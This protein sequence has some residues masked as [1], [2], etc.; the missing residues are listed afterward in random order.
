MIESI[1]RQFIVYEKFDAIH[2][3]IDYK[4]SV[5]R[6][7]LKEIK[8]KLFLFDKYNKIILFLIKFILIL[9]NKLFIMKHVFN[10]KKTIL[11]KIIMQE[12]ILSHTYEDDG[13]SNN[14][15]KTINSSIINLI[16][17][18]RQNSSFQ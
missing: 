18:S 14:N 10:I 7:Y 13:N 16:E 4:V 8:R 12:I 9:K 6:V 2:Q 17:I 11:L 5:F 1:N 15:I 3:K